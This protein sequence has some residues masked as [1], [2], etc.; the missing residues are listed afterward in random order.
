MPTRRTLN[1]LNRL[2]WDDRHSGAADPVEA[3]AGRCDEITLQ[4]VALAVQPVT[5]HVASPVSKS[6]METGVHFKIQGLACCQ[7]A[8]QSV[9]D[10][11]L[12][13]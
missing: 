2:S 7:F 1:A 11:F 3:I 4:G 6:W 13:P 12:L 8:R 10:N 9:P 5:P